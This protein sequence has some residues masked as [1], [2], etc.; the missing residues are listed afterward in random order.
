MPLATTPLL[1]PNTRSTHDA[2][3]SPP[4]YRTTCSSSPGTWNRSRTRPNVV[5]STSPRV[6]VVR[7]RSR[8]AAISPGA[9]VDVDD[10]HVGPELASDAPQA[11]AHHP[12]E[13][14]AI[15]DDA[16]TATQ[17]VAEQLLAPG[18]TRPTRRRP[19][20]GP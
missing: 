16:L 19:G 20:S 14:D 9:V 12:P 11:I 18:D 13:G 4:S 1:H 2:T 6:G 8:R 7:L 15:P 17:P 3:G 5:S 10:Q